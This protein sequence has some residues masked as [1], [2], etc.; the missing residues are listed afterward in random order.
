MFETV[1][2]YGNCLL[3]STSLTRLLSHLSS[4]EQV[5]TVV[6]YSNDKYVKSVAKE[7]TRSA[8]QHGVYFEIPHKLVHL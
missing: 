6:L 1:D 4:V 8:Q 2:A 7:E 3:S 5:T